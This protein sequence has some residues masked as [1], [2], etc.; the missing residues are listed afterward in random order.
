MQDAALGEVV[1]SGEEVCAFAERA[2]RLCKRRQRPLSVE[3]DP[4]PCRVQR[5]GWGGRGPSPLAV[6]A[7]KWRQGRTV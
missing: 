7:A 1:V 6:V 2:A 3:E 4:G 5:C